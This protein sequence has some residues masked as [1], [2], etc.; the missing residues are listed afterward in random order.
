MKKEYPDMKVS[1]MSWDTGDYRFHFLLF[2]S[3]W[4]PIKVLFI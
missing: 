1:K 4:S 3:L 2:K